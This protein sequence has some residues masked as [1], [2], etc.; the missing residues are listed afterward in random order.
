MV[1]FYAICL[2]LALLHVHFFLC[3][4]PVGGMRFGVSGLLLLVL[5]NFFQEYIPIG[6]KKFNAGKKARNKC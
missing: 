4:S 6:N 2:S 5:S 3:S 1:L